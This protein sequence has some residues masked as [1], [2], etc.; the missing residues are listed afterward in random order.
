VAAAAPAVKDTS[1]DFKIQNVKTKRLLQFFLADIFVV[2][3][4]IKVV[5]GI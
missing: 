4:E 2:L 5:N 3:I 1:M